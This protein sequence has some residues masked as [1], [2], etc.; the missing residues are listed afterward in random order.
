MTFPCLA[1]D[2]NGLVQEVRSFVKARLGATQRRYKA[3]DLRSRQSILASL[4]IVLFGVE[5]R[6]L[7]A[8]EV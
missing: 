5:E 2:E 7:G 6:L 3:E 8:P 4:L 1:V